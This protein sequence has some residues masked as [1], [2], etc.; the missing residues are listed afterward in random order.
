M[1][2]SRKLGRNELII[3]SWE[4]AT[5]RIAFEFAYR[6]YDTQDCDWIADEIGGV[7]VINDDFWDFDRIMEV[8]RLEPSKKKV[9][10]WYDHL[11]EEEY[12][13]RLKAFLAL[14]KKKG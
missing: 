14:K 12:P 3:A 1:S 7:F 9:Y 5:N 13:L 8:T 6:Y 11:M 4:E 10:A 2:N